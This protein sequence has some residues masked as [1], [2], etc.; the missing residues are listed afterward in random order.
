MLTQSQ[1]DQ[2]RLALASINDYSCSTVEKLDIDSMLDDR[3]IVESRDT[4][5]DFIKV[6][7]S[8]KPE[9]TLAGAVQVWERVQRFKGDPRKTLYVMEFDQFTASFLC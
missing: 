3:D 8:G 4:L 1:R 9:K 2:F 6:R 7:G 5:E